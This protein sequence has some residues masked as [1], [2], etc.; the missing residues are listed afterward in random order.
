M[1]KFQDFVPVE[2]ISW[3]NLSHNENAIDLLENNLDKINWYNLSRNLNAIH[4]L[5]NNLDEVDW[6]M[7]SFN[8]NINQLIYNLSILYSYKSLNNYL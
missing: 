8:P 2:K 3:E 1:Y 5:E 4:I 6:D 7:L